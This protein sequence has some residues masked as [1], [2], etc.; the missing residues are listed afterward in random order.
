VNKR[1]KPTKC[2]NTYNTHS[3]RSK[4]G[5]NV[6]KIILP[7]EEDLRCFSIAKDVGTARKTFAKYGQSGL[8]AALDPQPSNAGIEG[9]DDLS[10]EQIDVLR[11]CRSGVPLAGAANPKMFAHIYCDTY[12]NAALSESS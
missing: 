12:T 4:S 10:T 5:N 6:R 2:G 8:I 7:D 3:A 1:T 9:Y 11:L